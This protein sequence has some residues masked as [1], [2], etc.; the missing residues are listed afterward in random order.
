MG[1][2]SQLLSKLFE[3]AQWSR[4]NNSEQDKILWIVTPV[5][6]ERGSLDQGT[7]TQWSMLLED[8]GTT[9]WAYEYL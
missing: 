6:L 8:Y 4:Q 3:I 1:P 5:G 2:D 9:I 7:Q